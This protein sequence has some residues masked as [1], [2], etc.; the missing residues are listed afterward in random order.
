MSG[1]KNKFSTFKLFKDELVPQWYRNYYIV[2]AQSLEE[3]VEKV[4]CNEIF[5]HD[6]ELLEEYSQ[7][8]I[9]I[10]ILNEDEDVLYET[11]L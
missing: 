3:A 7:E 10:E 6:T 11:D 4:K 9:K 2:D 5:P 1:E 8:P